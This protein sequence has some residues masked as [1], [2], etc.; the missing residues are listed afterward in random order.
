MLTQE[1]L[2]Q[3]ATYNPE[4]GLLVC[5]K[6]RKGSKNKIGD[7]LGSVNKVGYFEVQIDNR[8]YFVHR[9]ACLYLTGTMPN[10]V[11]DHINRNPSDNRWANLR[12]VTQFE[13]SRNA[14]RLAERNSTGY[15]GVHLWNGKYRA[16]IVIKQKQVHLGTFDDALTA[17]AAYQVAKKQHQ[18]CLEG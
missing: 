4:T 11:V 18:P 17:A 5:V 8:R 15:V 14:N 12:V 6:N 1:R 9:L 7:T 10:G 3:L 13:N 2:K 16:K